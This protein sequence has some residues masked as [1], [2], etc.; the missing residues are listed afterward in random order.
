MQTRKAI[1]VTFAVAFALLAA[2]APAAQALTPTFTSTTT[3]VEE[4]G[5]A[6]KNHVLE[7]NFGAITCPKSSFAATLGTNAMVVRGN[8]G[9]SECKLGG[10]AATVN[11]NGC[12]YAFQPIYKEE[13]NRYAG[14]ATIECATGKKIEF[15]SGLCTVSLPP[16]TAWTVQFANENNAGG[17]PSERWTTTAAEKNIEYTQG[18]FCKGGAGTFKNGKYSGAETIEGFDPVSKKPI[19]IWIAEEN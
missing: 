5:T 13:L 1:P 14:L 3:P 8:A 9:Y 12:Q 19:W 6:T 10:E 17:I 7:G 4:V 15:S 18:A 11:M 16:Q 2:I